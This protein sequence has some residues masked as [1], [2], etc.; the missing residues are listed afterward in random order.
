MR[1]LGRPSLNAPIPLLAASDQNG[2]L[3]TAS[4]GEN[5]LLVLL[6]PLSGLVTLLQTPFVELLRQEQPEDWAFT[7]RA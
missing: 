7:W 3:Q 6:Q 4:I 1:M 5:G 2:E